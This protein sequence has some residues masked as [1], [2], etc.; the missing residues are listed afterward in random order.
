[1]QIAVNKKTRLLSLQARLWNEISSR[2]LVLVTQESM[3]PLG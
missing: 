3:R 1:M 2:F